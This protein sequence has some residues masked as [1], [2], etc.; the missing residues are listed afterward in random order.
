MHGGWQ[1]QAGLASGS[2]GI[3]SDTEDQILTSMELPRFTSFAWM[4]PE[5]IGPG[6]TRKPRILSRRIEGHF[7]R[8]ARSSKSP[9]D[10][11]APGTEHNALTDGHRRDNM[12][13]G[14]HQLPQ[15]GTLVLVYSWCYKF[16][17]TA[18]DKH[19]NRDGQFVLCAETGLTKPRHLRKFF[20]Q[21]AQSYF[22]HQLKI[23]SRAATA[24]ASSSGCLS[25]SSVPAHRE[26]LTSVWA[27]QS[28]FS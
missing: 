11:L 23:H 18:F 1:T 26:A 28:G 6:R 7:F 5:A 16:Q 19:I 15:V 17:E 27:L 10:H 20:R 9:T 2:T 22:H 12:L 8:L 25:L 14:K 3:W 24:L 4:D 13:P 21:A